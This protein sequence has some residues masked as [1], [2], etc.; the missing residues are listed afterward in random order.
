MARVRVVGILAR[1]CTLVNSL[2]RVRVRVRV[3]VKG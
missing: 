3:R 1:G 2:V